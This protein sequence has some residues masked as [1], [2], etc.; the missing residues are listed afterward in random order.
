MLR[1]KIFLFVAIAT[2]LVTRGLLAATGYPKV[3]TGELHI[4]HVLWGGLLLGAA[5]VILL[6]GMGTQ[7]R[8]WAAFIA[9]IGF[10][11][12]I[13]ELGKFLTKD[14]NYFYT[15]AVAIMYIVF[16]TAYL[17]VRSLTLRRKL[18]DERRMALAGSA[19]TDQALGELDG[20]RR[21]KILELLDEMQT[22][23][24]SS[25]SIRSAL[26]SHPVA[27]GSLRRRVNRLTA[28]SGQVLRG[29]A[30]NTVVQLIAW[31]V[32]AVGVGERLNLYISYLFET[33][34]IA[35]INDELTTLDNT[36]TGLDLGFY[37]W[38]LLMANLL[39]AA[40]VGIGLITVLI[41]RTRTAGLWLV[42]WGLIL[43]LLFNQFS[44]FK[45]EQFWALIGFAVEVASIL[46]ARHLLNRT[47]T[48]TPRWQAPAP[49]ARSGSLAPLEM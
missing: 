14:V 43:D 18:S 39:C 36:T 25:A 1:F 5:V 16:V 24:A 10:G 26:E 48:S 49:R 15:P 37:F 13:D 33:I 41:P 22:P 34:E 40:I 19:V 20:V 12:F 38:Y 21:D 35:R 47:R 23:T 8:T 3:G 2:V 11:L 46:L 42:Q 32:L 29:L 6:I 30:S 17:L 44:T 31:L 4:A 27:T 9:G 45:T 7:V 28:V